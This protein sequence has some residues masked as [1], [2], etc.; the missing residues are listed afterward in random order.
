VELSGI[1]NQLQELVDGVRSGDV[2]RSDA[3][4]AGQLLNYQTAC[5]KVELAAREQEELVTRLEAVETAIEE[6]RRWP[7]RA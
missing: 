4:V 3:S 2:D 7:H 1:R 6:Q 5:L